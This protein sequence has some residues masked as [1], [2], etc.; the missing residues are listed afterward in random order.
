MQPKSCKC[1]PEFLTFYTNSLVFAKVNSITIP[2][3]EN[4]FAIMGC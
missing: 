1:S 3:L 4:K 2:L